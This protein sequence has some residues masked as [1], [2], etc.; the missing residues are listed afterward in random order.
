MSRPNPL[1]PKNQWIS[2]SLRTARGQPINEIS[3]VENGGSGKIVD[4]SRAIPY[5]VV[6]DVIPIT[7][8]I[9]DPEGLP[10]AVHDPIPYGLVAGLR[11]PME[12]NRA[13]IDSGHA[14]VPDQSH[15]GPTFSA[16]VDAA[17]EVQCAPVKPGPEILYRLKIPSGR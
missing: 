13:Q 10:A 7:R 12:F 6:V 5:L 11:V 2:K 15:A 14:I 4:A 16:H 3:C 17:P 1:T 9:Q 8:R